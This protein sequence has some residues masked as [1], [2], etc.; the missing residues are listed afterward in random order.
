MQ[1]GLIRSYQTPDSLNF[2]LLELLTINVFQIFS[3][4]QVIF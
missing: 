1:N 2:I 3:Q 4:Y